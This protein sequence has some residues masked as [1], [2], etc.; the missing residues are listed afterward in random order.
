M[1]WRSRERKPRTESSGGYIWIGFPFDLFFRLLHAGVVVVDPL[2]SCQMK[3]PSAFSLTHSR[4]VFPL[5]SSFFLVISC[6][7]SLSKRSRP[8]LLRGILSSAGGFKFSHC[9]CRC[10]ARYLFPTR[11]FLPG[12]N[13]HFPKEEN[14]NKKLSRGEAFDKCVTEASTQ[15]TQ[16]LQFSSNKK[17]RLFFPIGAIISSPVYLEI[18]RPWPRLCVDNIVF[19]LETRRGNRIRR[20]GGKV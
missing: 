1:L 14:K 17:K 15:R 18:G 4:Y 11:R 9:S 20:E 16:G 12:H 6:V 19:C 7:A 10:F 5:F 2:P 3:F 13:E 8:L